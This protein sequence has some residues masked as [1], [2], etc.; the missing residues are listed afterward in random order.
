MALPPSP[1]VIPVVTVQPTIGEVVEDV[2]NGLVPSD[3]FWVSVY[4]SGEPS[5]HTKVNI[6][7]DEE[8]RD[9]VR[10]TCE[11]GGVV[12]EPDRRDDKVSI[13]PLL[14]SNGLTGNRAIASLLIYRKQ[15]FFAPLKSTATVKPQIPPA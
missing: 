15:R 1:R 13:A 5:I 12:F 3:K 6:E 4:K 10:F 9:L 7:L 11:D 2:K 14:L 8:D